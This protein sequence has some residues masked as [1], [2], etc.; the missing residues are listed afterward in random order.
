MPADSAYQPLQP[1]RRPGGKPTHA[2]RYRVLIHR[3][4]HAHWTQIV[5]RVGLDSAQQLWDH[6]SAHPGQ[7]PEINSSCILKGRAGRPHGEGWSR[8][9]HYE[10]S[11]KARVNY[12][13][14]DRF[15]IGAQSDE[16]PVVAILTIDYTS[17]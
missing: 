13:F 17:H 3:K 2:P 6:L 12:Q 16:H 10:L 1:A 11:S 7:V 15:T 14:H 4:Y 5:D 8:T 9:V